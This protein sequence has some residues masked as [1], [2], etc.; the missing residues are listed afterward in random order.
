MKKYYV[1]T[2]YQVEEMRL[3]QSKISCNIE[4]LKKQ[5]S[6]SN[7]NDNVNITIDNISLLNEEILEILEDE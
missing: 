2:P 1:L 3:I 7:D 6:E 5:L 4:L